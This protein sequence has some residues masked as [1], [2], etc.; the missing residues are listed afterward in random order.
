VHSNQ[1]G[2]VWQVE[3]HG[4]PDATDLTNIFGNRTSPERPLGKR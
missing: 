3:I 2:T 1:I 4:G